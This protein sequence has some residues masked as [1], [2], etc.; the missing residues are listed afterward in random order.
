LAAIALAV[1][2]VVVALLWFLIAGGYFAAFG[3]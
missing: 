1:T 3:Q 2:G